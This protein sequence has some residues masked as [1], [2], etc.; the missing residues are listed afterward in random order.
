MSEAT[1]RYAPLSVWCPLSGMSRSTTYEA[2]GDGRLRAI[3][4]GN[5][6]LIDVEHGLAY[7]ASLPAAKIR[8]RYR[9][10]EQ[11]TVTSR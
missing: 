3:K 6:T 10:A 1:P 2:L 11:E 4:L 9:A 8:S 7:L 5:R